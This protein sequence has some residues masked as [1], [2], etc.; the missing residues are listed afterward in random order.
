MCFSTG[1]VLVLCLGLFIFLM[2]QV[3]ITLYACALSRGAGAERGDSPDQGWERRCRRLF[4][5][6]CYRLTLAITLARSALLARA[7]MSVERSG[8][9]CI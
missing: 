2:R 7:S 6:P 1:E 5:C 3:L 8:R 4:L 9:A